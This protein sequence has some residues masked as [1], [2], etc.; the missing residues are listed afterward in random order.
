MTRRSLP[1][2]IGFALL[3]LFVFTIPIE[4]SIEIPGLGT[5]SRGVGGIAMAGG[6][7]AVLSQGRLRLPS[8]IHIAIA[9]FV[10]WSA[11]TVRWSILPDYTQE[12][13]NTYLQLLCLLWLVWELCTEER[14]ILS[15]LDAYVLGTFP[16]AAQTIQQF[17][18]GHQAMYNRY[19][20]EGLDPNDMALSLALSLPMSYYLSLHFHG[21]RAWLCR[22]QMLAVIGTI[23]LTSSR[24][25]ALAMLCG[26]SLVL[27]TLPAISRR[28]RMGLAI[29]LVLTVVTAASV[30]PVVSWKRLATLGSEISAGTLNMRT[31][32]WAA[33][34]HAFNQQPLGGVG[35]GAYPETTVDRLG[36]PWLF[37]PVAH[38]AYV[39][40]LVETGLVGAAL[41][42]TVLGMLGRAAL[43]FTGIT[44]TFW[45]TLLFTWAL[46]VASLSWEYRK[47][48]WIIFGL[49]AA[50]A[51]C[52]INAAR[53]AGAVR[54]SAPAA[55]SGAPGWARERLV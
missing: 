35:A 19:A 42:A 7:F 38:N 14:H 23:L 37:H 24:G 45:C 43:H 55:W 1:V 39:S 6:L 46:G 12:R 33:G 44:R 10:C 17:L 5:I 40:V 41:Y 48:T 47:P 8:G 30:V 53:T 9:A 32:I 27:W 28:A 52:K 18:M 11:F 29:L 3:W 51:G 13:M 49:L 15:L 2:R 36:R 4:K 34:I 22:V 21:V 25:G 20:M 16:V 54:M 26:L 50:H 31:I